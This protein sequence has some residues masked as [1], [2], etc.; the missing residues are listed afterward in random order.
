[1]K[2][3]SVVSLLVVGLAVVAT[4]SPA[5]AQKK[6]IVG[7]PCGSTCISADKVCHL[8]FYDPAYPWAASPRGR[9]YYANLQTCRGMTRLKSLVF[10]RTEREAVRAGLRRSR[11]EG[12]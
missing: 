4:P 9:T 5:L 2:L 12:C 8:R 1:M 6:C 10:Y 11:Q 7:I 3:P